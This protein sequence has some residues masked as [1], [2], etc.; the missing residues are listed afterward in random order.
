MKEKILNQ[1]KN[2]Y[3]G[4]FRVAQKK[5]KPSRTIFEMTAKDHQQQDRQ[6]ELIRELRASGEY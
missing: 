5:A 6:Y 2:S 1:T 4:C 3:F